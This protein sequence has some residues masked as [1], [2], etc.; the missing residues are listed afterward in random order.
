MNRYPGTTQNLLRIN[1]RVLAD[2]NLE[3]MQ[4]PQC[5]NPIALRHCGPP[6]TVGKN[7][8]LR[9]KQRELLIQKFLPPELPLLAVEAVQPNL[10]ML[11]VNQKVE[12]KARRLKPH[13]LM[14]NHLRFPKAVR[15]AGDP[16]KFRGSGEPGATPARTRSTRPIGRTSTSAE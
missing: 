7:R 16:T 9:K 12:V 1:P 6:R 2:K 14:T 3:P 13:D 5:K 10:P 4:K 8:E 11:A 15:G